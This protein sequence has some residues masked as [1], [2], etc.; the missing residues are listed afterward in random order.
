[1]TVGRD[2]ASRS[3]DL[4]GSVSPASRARSGAGRTRRR[5]LQRHGFRK[6]SI[7]IEQHHPRLEFFLGLE[8]GIARKIERLDQG[9]LFDRQ[10][11]LSN[12]D[13]VFHVTSQGDER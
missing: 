12:C 2:P 4:R 6:D 1:M 3:R 8:V 13:D 9:D 10:E 5:K 7:P 11:S